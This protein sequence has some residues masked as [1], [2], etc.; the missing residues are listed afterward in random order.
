MCKY[1]YVCVC[2]YDM[3]VCVCVCVYVC[4]HVCICIYVCMCDGWMDVR[5]T[6]NFCVH[7]LS[8]KGVVVLCVVSDR[9][10]YLPEPAV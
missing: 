1:V 8:V 7:L 9:A 10:T 6:R 3:C 4:M 5:P 2:V